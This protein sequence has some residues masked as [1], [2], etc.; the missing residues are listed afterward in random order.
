[1]G[2]RDS[3]FKPRKPR[4]QTWDERERQKKGTNVTRLYH[5]TSPEHLAIILQTGF[6]KRTESNVSY[7]K[8]HAA[9]DVVWLTNQKLVSQRWQQ[10]SA[11][12]KGAVRITVDVPDAQPW[13]TWSR[14]HGIKEEVYNTLNVTGGGDAENWYVV[15]REVLLDE[16]EEIR[17][18]KRGPQAIIPKTLIGEIRDYV[19]GTPEYKAGFRDGA[20]E[21][22]GRAKRPF[23]AS[24][25][26]L[27]AVDEAMRSPMY[28]TLRV[29][30]QDLIKNS[31]LVR[32]RSKVRMSTSPPV[33]VTDDPL[34]WRYL[35]EVKVAKESGFPMRNTG[36]WEAIAEKRMVALWLAQRGKDG[37]TLHFI[38][39][40]GPNVGQD[41]SPKETTL[42]PQQLAFDIA[43]S[44]TYLWL[45]EMER[46]AMA[47]P[48]PQHT[49]E[50]TCAPEES[51]FWSR[52]TGN[53]L[54]T[55][56]DWFYIR[57]TD[58]ALLVVTDVINEEAGEIG[59]VSFVVKF[60]G[61]YPD[62][63]VEHDGFELI[64]GVLQRLAFL[65]SRYTGRERRSTQDM[66]R[67]I[68]REYARRKLELPSD[69][70]SIVTLRRPEPKAKGDGEGKH[71]DWQHQW[72][73]SAH[74]RNQAL[75][76]GRTERQLRWIP[77][78]IKGPE[79]KPIL[80]RVYTVAR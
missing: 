1:M 77:A 20:Q 33:V 52:E 21:S 71:I 17:F 73:V 69:E 40:D 18:T 10:W 55:G 9:P 14:A 65:N 58:R 46:L 51:M 39:A 43:N 49:I 19:M 31:D 6:L 57:R 68:R 78:Y 37:G 50:A 64:T 30:N 22:A 59:L 66:P 35:H 79:D 29:A 23:V 28:R 13:S 60:G 76:P 45:E 2:H 56:V 48:L 75:G 4:G 16:F 80:E 8:E 38:A 15:E 42:T 62:D 26:I 67:E 41:L 54:R 11:V 61:V 53:E 36:A 12:D 63:Y 7:T 25:P 3:G 27:D 72:W 34:V 32:S 70:I 5:Y 74:W 44:N 47:A 24:F